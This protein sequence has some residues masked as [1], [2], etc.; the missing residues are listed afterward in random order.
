[1]FSAGGLAPNQKRQSVFF[2]L[3]FLSEK[4]LSSTPRFG[5]VVQH[6]V[7]ASVADAPYRVLFP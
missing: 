4:V 7:V 2:F 5:Y 1:M 6:L 3:F